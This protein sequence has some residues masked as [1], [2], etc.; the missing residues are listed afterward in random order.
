MSRRSQHTAN[1][2][3]LDLRL[4]GIRLTIHYLPYPLLAFL[5]SITGSVTTALWLTR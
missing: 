1:H 4:G 2:P 3:L 5:A